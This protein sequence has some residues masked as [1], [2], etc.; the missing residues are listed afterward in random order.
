MA[1]DDF[2][3]RDAETLKALSDPLRVAVIRAL[4]SPRTAKE[5]ARIVDRDVTTLYYHLR[6]LEKHGLI[7]VVETRKT[8]AIPESV[9]QAAARRYHLADQLISAGAGDE[10]EILLGALFDG[11]KRE[12]RHSI[13]QGAIRVNEDGVLAHYQARLTPAQFKRFTARL[14]R[15]AHD[16]QAAGAANPDDETTL[17]VGITLALYPYTGTDDSDT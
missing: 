4:D 13:R 16:L 1:A 17:P 6:L 2:W 14:Q 3:I 11:T 5:V 12:V 8:S 10:V 15:L 7:T 9:Y